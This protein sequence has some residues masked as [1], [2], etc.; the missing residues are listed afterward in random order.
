MIKVKDNNYEDLEQALADIPTDNKEEIIIDV[1]GVIKGQL[2]IAKP[3]LRIRNA[4]F[5]NNY[6]GYEI[7]DDGRYIY[8]SVINGDDFT[9][10]KITRD[11]EYRRI[12]E[13][14]MEMGE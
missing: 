5:I 7:L 3:H 12:A 8:R 14:Y 13:A 4:T 10:Q 9:V 2:R 6:G 1:Q 11:F